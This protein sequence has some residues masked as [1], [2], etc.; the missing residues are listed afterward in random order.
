MPHSVT[1]P[2][3]HLFSYGTLQL[4][5]VQHATFGRKLEGRADQ[6]SGY[7]LTLLEIRDPAVVATSG[8]THHPI[9][10]YTGH[11]QDRV[12]G[13]VLEITAAELR[14]ADAYE[15]SDYRRDHVI[16]VS[17]LAAWVYVDARSPAAQHRT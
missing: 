10:A 9:V 16:L 13:T 4:E 6:L 17:G 1:E 7:R 3:E 5:A 2:P 11:E 8:K 15:V 14:D 12:E